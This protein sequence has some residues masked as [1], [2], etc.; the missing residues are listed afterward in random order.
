MI[1]LPMSDRN[2]SIVNRDESRDQLRQIAMQD[3]MRDVQI[4]YSTQHPASPLIMV[5]VIA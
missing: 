4:Y 5:K 3:P 2:P 1:H